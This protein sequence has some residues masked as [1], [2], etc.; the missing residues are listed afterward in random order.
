MNTFLSLKWMRLLVAIP[1]LSSIFG[2]TQKFNDVSATVQEAY[3]NYIDVEL[4]PQEIEAVPYASAYLKIGDQ[5]QVFVVLAFA[6]QNLLTGNTQ[7]KW[8]SADKAMVVTENG[9]IVKT[10]GLQ[11]TN[12]VGIY[13]NVPAYSAPSLQYSLSYDWSDKYRYGFPAKVQRSRQGKESVITPIS[14][15]TT[16]VYTEVVTF[17][18]LEKTVENQYWVNGK[19]EVVKTRQHLGPNMV[20]V[21]LTI[22][23]GYSKS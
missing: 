11:T 15:T 4:T 5:K 16:D 17:T 6:E 1:L 7:L 21:E 19:G 14:S 9:H 2:C 8:V 12:L 20:P 3:G 13:G 18:S 22:L 23:K 10:I